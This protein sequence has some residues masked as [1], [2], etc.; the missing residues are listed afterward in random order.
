MVRD[1]FIRE[2]WVSAVAANESGRNATRH[3]QEFV[4]PPRAVR[5]AASTSF[6]LLETYI[7]A[8]SSVTSCSLP[9]TAHS[10]V[11]VSFSQQLNDKCPRDRPFSVNTESFL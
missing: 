11:L 7:Y 5:K 9:S 6:I 8:A 10:S 4:G 1:Q 3:E 2:M